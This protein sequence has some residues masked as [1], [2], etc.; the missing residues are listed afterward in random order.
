MRRLL[1][2]LAI[3]A[4]AAVLGAGCGG[5]DSS[6]G[7]LE[8]ALAYMPTDTPFVVAIESNVEGEQYQALDDILGRFPGG[9]SV[10]QRLLQELEEGEERVS[11][12]DD[13]KPLLGNPFVVSGTDAAA[14]IGSEGDTPFIAAVEVA[15]T[16]ALDR[17]IEKTKPEERG[18]TAGATLYGDDGSFF[19]VEDDMVVFADSEDVL[20]SALERADGDDH[21]DVET[22][23]KGLEGLPEQTLARVYVDVQA[24][25]EQDPDARLAR[26]V[27]WVSALRTLGMTAT[28]AD[29]SIDIEV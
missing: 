29:D 15:D 7:S 23:E 24:L 8:S 6:G 26:R 25:I 13:V 19:A 22:F 28:A 21:L 9:D 10:K 2:T 18:E 27:E 4:A 5:D 12:E 20:E 17:L 16:D 3:L 14:L 11:Y 1:T